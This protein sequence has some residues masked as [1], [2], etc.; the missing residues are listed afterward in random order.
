LTLI[1]AEPDNIRHMNAMMMSRLSFLVLA[2]A[3]AVALLAI[4]CGGDDAEDLA[5]PAT[6]TPVSLG[7]TPAPVACPAPITTAPEPIMKQFDAKPDLTID[8]SKTYTAVVKTERGEITMTLRPDLAPEHVNSLV[9]LARE[10]YYDGIT[11]HRVEPGFVIQGG[12]PT[13]TGGGGPG[14]TLP[15]EFSS[16]PFARGILGMARTNDPNSAGSQWFVTLGDA[17]HLNN[18]YTVFGSVTDGM[19]VVDC[20]QVGDKIVTVE[21]TEE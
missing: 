2:L 1:V 16:E 15:A 8:T 20:I 5:D 17:P 6:D 9:F 13:G 7:F 3:V 18:Q 19:D 10:G 21:I 11:F 12:D 14:Y 4:A